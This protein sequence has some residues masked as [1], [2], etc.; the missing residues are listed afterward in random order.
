M[1]L[2]DETRSAIGLRSDA[3]G[4]GQIQ[5]VVFLAC[6]P[7]LNQLEHKNAERRVH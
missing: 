3:I 1:T 2:Q 6:G 5:L 4:T 7:A